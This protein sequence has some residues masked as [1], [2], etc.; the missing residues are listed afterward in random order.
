MK[1]LFKRLFP[2]L[3]LCLLLITVCACQADKFVTVACISKNTSTEKSATYSRFDGT[4]SYTFTVKEGETCTIK[5]SFTTEGGKISASIYE[6]ENPE[7]HLYEGN[8]IP[9]SEFTV[10]IEES[11]KY[12]IRLEAEDHEGGYSFLWA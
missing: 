12:V 1:K 5:V 10:N 6:K 4:R 7:K 8:D 11:G 2:A 3:L 9:T